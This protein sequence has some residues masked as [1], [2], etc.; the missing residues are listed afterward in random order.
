MVASISTL[1]LLL[2]GVLQKHEIQ[3]PNLFRLCSM[4]RYVSGKKFQDYCLLNRL[5]KLSLF[6]VLITLHTQQTR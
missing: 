3:V 6:I 5:L 1:D 4:L 2:K